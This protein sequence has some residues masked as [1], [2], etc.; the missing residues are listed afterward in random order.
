MGKISIKYK[1]TELDLDYRLDVY[2]ENNVAAF[3]VTNLNSNIPIPKSFLIFCYPVGSDGF[4]NWQETKMFHFHTFKK[5]HEY[6]EMEEN[7]KQ[8]VS[9]RLRAEMLAADH[10]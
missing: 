7:I 8:L 9:D 1:Q 6:E 3:T 2:P 4:V 10:A 5:G